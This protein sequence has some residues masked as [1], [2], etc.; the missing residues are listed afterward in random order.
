MNKDEDIYLVE[1]HQ[2][3]SEDAMELLVMKYQRLIYT[4]IF[5][6][7][8]DVEDAKDLTQ[9]TFLY[10]VRSINGFKRDSSFKT[11]LCKIAVNTCINHINRRRDEIELDDNIAGR[12]SSVVSGLID[13]EIKGYIEESLTKLPAR[14]RTALILRAYEGL[15]CAETSEI[16]GCT[17]GA[18]KAHYHH[19]VVKLKEMLKEKGYEIK[20]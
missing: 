5:R 15:S 12:Q 18:V 13:K 9:Q 19:A 4:I 16:M 8:R 1:L 7:V 10:V 2:S 6:M 11:W 3:G 20:S 14:Q 17:E